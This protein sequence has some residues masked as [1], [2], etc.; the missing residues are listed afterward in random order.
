MTLSSQTSTIGIACDL[1]AASRIAA[2]SELGATALL[3]RTPPPMIEIVDPGELGVDGPASNSD[4][5]LRGAFS[6]CGLAAPE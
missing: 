2:T 1:M 3:S 6:G 4:D 5:G